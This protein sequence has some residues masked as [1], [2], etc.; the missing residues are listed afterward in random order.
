MSIEAAGRFAGPGNAIGAR[1]LVVEPLG[2]KMDLFVNAGGDRR[3]VARID[4]RENLHVGDELNLYVDT[5]R[6]YIFEPGPDGNSL[7]T[8]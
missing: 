5:R 4:A 2:E 3:A 1:V 7:L 6:L 8:A